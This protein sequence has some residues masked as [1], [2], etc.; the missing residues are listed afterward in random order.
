ML[1]NAL[2]TM[3]AAVRKA[4]TYV[5]RDFYEGENRPQSKGVASFFTKTDLYSENNI[6]KEL[7]SAGYKYHFLTE[8][9]SDIAYTCNM[10]AQNQNLIWVLDPLDGTTNFINHHPLIGISLALAR[11][12]VEND[13]A[14]IRDVI[15]GV[16]Y[17]PILSEAYFST[18]EGAFLS[19]KNG[20][21]VKLHNKIAG[22]LEKTA[23]AHSIF[24]FSFPK[25]DMDHTSDKA[26]QFNATLEKIK[27]FQCCLRIS[28]SIVS[29]M[30]YL[31][32]G[33][34]VA[35]MHYSCKIWDVA[36]GFAILKQSNYKFISPLTGEY[37]SDPE[38]LCTSGFIAGNSFVI[39]LLRREFFA[40]A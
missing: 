2:K 18:L 8:E 39:N 33:K 26:A 3:L 21:N 13:K 15:V 9:N 35:V 1:D 7:F 17:L 30:I 16:I 31:L 19:D 28:G 37:L 10:Q 40:K 23:L 14:I 11:G 24:M 29:D 20:N 27:A 6:V 38:S 22:K 5:S 36:A 12:N 25:E 32:T 4:G 34:A